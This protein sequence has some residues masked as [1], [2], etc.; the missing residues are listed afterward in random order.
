MVALEQIFYYHFINLSKTDMRDLY[1]GMKN[2][3]NMTDLDNIMVVNQ[4]MQT[5]DDQLNK[6]T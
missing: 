2:K 3:I 6:K 1:I 5:I 4:T